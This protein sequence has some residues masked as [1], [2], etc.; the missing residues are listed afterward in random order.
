MPFLTPNSLPTGFVCRQL[1]IPDDPEWLEVVNGALVELIKAYNWEAFGTVT[2]VQAA[3]R[4]QAMFL[5]YLESSCL[6]GAIMPYG[7][8]QPPDNTLPCDGSLHQR[9][10]Y[11]K[12]Y[13]RLESALIVDGGSFRTPDL[14]GRFVL[15]AD[16]D[17]QPL[18]EGGESEITLTV[19]QMPEHGH[20]SPPH[21]HSNLPHDHVS[22]PH[23]HTEVIPTPTVINGG[24]EAPAAGAVPTPSVTGAASAII[25]PNSI[26]IGDTAVTIN[27]TGGGEAHPN[28]PPFTALN[29]CIV[30]K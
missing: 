16:V 19:G 22:P 4:M 12:L 26:T 6:I 27:S 2:P 11:P 8:I 29:Y 10:D 18:D 13:D 14:R 30:A 5:E 25:S 17:N 23:F 1:H 24:I 3:E 9:D 7:T 28:M 20:T 21:G 15:A